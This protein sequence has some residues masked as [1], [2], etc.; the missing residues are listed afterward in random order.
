VSRTTK[1]I[2]CRGPLPCVLIVSPGGA[3]VLE[4]DSGTTNL[5]IPLTL[6]SPFR[7]QVTVEWTTIFDP[8][9]SSLAA[10][11][12]VDYQTASG[13]VTF[14]AGDTEQSVTVTVIGDELIESDELLV[15]SFRNPTNAQMGG[16]WGLGFGGITNDDA[17]P[18]VLPGA[19][20]TVEGDAGTRVLEVPVTMSKPSPQ[21][22]TTEWTT[23]FD[24]SWSSLAAR[25]DEDYEA[26][27]G[28]VTFAPGQ[29]A[30]TVTISVTGDTTF[31]SDELLVVSFRN[32]TNAQIGGFWGLGFGGITNDDQPVT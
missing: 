12:D 5:Q 13:V 18:T 16:F 26:A 17:T 8:S 30:Q 24:P 10:Q 28:V 19:A 15:V 11:P 9:W 27:S 1:L 2:V 22:I 21:T 29:T 4:G 32:P 31:E 14:A 20:A 7:T 23:I 25:P 6:S 3:S